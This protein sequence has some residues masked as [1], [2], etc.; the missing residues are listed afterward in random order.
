MFSYDG[1]PITAYS[2]GNDDLVMCLTLDIDGIRETIEQKYGVK[3]VDS[4][5]WELWLASAKHI[6]ENFWA[7]IH[8]QI[9]QKQMLVCC[10]NPKCKRYGVPAGKRWDEPFTYIQSFEMWVCPDCGGTDVH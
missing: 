6:E 5:L 7:E 3:L 2:T 9:G 4:Q 10:H 8:Y 1:M